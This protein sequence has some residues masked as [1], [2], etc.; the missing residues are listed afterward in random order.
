MLYFFS[1]RFTI[2]WSI[3]RSV[4]IVSI[5]LLP[6]ETKLFVNG[7][8]TVQ[9]QKNIFWENEKIEISTKY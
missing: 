7:S 4:C 1:V 8:A 2:R 6:F 5:V 9:K 3:N